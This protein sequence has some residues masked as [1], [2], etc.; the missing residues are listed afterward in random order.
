MRQKEADVKRT[1]ELSFELSVKQTVEG[2]EHELD[3]NLS[4]YNK[5][6]TN[7]IEEI[8][9]QN[10]DYFVEDLQRRVGIFNR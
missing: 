1:K 10:V 3:V 9:K 2:I 5:Q 7:D 6:T 8:V 4:G